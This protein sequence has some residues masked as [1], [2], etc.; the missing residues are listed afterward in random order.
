MTLRNY[1]LTYDPLA[2]AEILPQLLAFIQSN[3]L[4][5]Q[6]ITPYVGCV[7]I[8]SDSDISL[9]SGSYN[10]FFNGRPFMLAEV[11]HTATGGRLDQ[12]IWN[13]LNNAVPPPL[14]YT[15]LGNG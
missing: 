8:K 3:A 13:W 1:V 4:T 5:Y 10:S 12:N 14:P 11:H 9:I 2:V 15:P 7:L 6:F